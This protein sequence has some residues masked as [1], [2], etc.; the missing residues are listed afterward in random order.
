MK[1]S[2]YGNTG[3]SR[4]IDKFYLPIMGM[5]YVTLVSLAC[6]RGVGFVRNVFKKKSCGASLCKSE[7]ISIVQEELD[8]RENLR[9]P[10]LDKLLQCVNQGL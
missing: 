3:D 6:K 2:Q 10:I 8:R 7:I 4:N 1:K 5:R 9:K